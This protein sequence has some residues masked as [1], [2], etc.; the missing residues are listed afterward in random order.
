MPYERAQFFERPVV[1]EDVETLAG[2]E[3]VLFMLALDALLPPSLGRLFAAALQ[4]IVQLAV[5]RFGGRGGGAHVADRNRAKEIG[6][7][8]IS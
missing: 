4:G 2:G 8:I 7:R 5:G 3:L 6:A 1:E